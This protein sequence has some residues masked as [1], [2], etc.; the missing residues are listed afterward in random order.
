M[1]ITKECLILLGNLRYKCRLC[2][3]RCNCGNCQVMETFRE[4]VCYKEIEWI[5]Q[6]MEEDSIMENCITLHPGFDVV[7][8]NIWTLQ[9]AYFN[10]R[11]HYGTE[12]LPT[13]VNEYVVIKYKLMHF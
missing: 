11:G 10:Y 12:T 13:S 3:N 2:V 4:Y 6:K 1:K 7:C 8:L 5:T 9:A